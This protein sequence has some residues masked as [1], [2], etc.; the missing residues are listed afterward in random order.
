M[1]PMTTRRL[2][3]R[4]HT[5]PRARRRGCAAQKPRTRRFRPAVSGYR[6]Y[7]P[8][9]GRWPNRDHIEEQGG[10]NLYAMVGNDPIHDNDPLGLEP[11]CPKTIAREKAILA[12]KYDQAIN[13]LETKNVPQCGTGSYSCDAINYALLNTLSSLDVK[14][15]SCFSERRSRIAWSFPAK[16]E[17]G[18][19]V[20][21]CI[22]R[23][24]EKVTF[25]AWFRR[26]AAEPPNFFY[27][28]YPTIGSPLAI[29][30]S[31][32]AHSL[33]PTG[34]PQIIDIPPVHLP[35]DTIDSRRFFFP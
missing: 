20:V 17:R 32:V 7:I 26:P 22:S 12:T 8:N 25:D 1:A 6:F 33:N 4:S 11:C 23:S 19:W 21:V 24:N 5:E 31:Q 29:D 27:D 34:A 13:I 10:I 30:S 18:H 15:W 35:K 3:R 2:H 28:R 9:T 16:E 14:C